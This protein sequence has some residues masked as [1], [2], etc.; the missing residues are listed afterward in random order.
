[1]N[2]L[3]TLLA[4]TCLFLL[5]SSRLLV[6]IRM[7]AFQ[8]FLLGILPF[9]VSG[10]DHVGVAAIILSLASIGLKGFLLPKLLTRAL[11]ESGARREIEPFIGFGASML[12]GVALLAVSSY[13]VNR[14]ETTAQIGS[15]ITLI[16]GFFMVFSGLFLLITRRKALTQT[17][18]FLV[19]ENGVFATGLSLG[20]EFSVFVELGILLD[21]FV[22]IFLM[23]I[24]L[25]HIDREFDHIDADR[26]NEL[27]DLA[28]DASEDEEVSE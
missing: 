17:L 2:T 9:F 5:G 10:S 24:M 20:S 1:M 15:S 19:L 25:F 14:L 8:G 3:A 12:S 27:S 4:L 26:F 11:F 13:I 28:F 7:V 21:V 6:S 22:G 18:G 16:A 23:G